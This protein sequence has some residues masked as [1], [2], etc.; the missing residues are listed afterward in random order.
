MLQCRPRRDLA[1]FAGDGFDAVRCD[2]SFINNSL[3]IDGGRD[4]DLLRIFN[5]DLINDAAIFG[6]EGGDAAYCESLRA[7]HTCSSIL[8]PTSVL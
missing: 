7:E 1:I 4:A 2:S 3:L 5:S 6:R 8:A